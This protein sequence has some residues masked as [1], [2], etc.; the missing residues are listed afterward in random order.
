MV[1]IVSDSTC[2]LTPELAARYDLTIVPLHILLGDAEYRDGENITQADIFKWADT[3]KT[4][5]K[6]SAVSIE[7]TMAAFKPILDAGNEIIAFH[8]SE[9]MSTTGNMMRMAAQELDAEDRI[10]V[11]NSENLTTCVGHLAIEASIMA[12]AGMDR[13][14][15]LE[16]IHRLIP[17]LRASFVVDTLIYLYRGG[18]CNAVAALAGGML[19]LHPRIFVENGAMDAGKKY[20]GKIGAVVRNYA[21]DMEAD[22]LKAKKERVFITHSMQGA[23]MK[24]VEETEAYL[25][26]LGHFDEVLITRTGGVVSSHCGPGTLGILFI[27]GE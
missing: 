6:T 11:V 4:T 25:K 2:D 22:L 27:A 9:S 26:S 15:I 10:T 7:D 12:A 20:R 18:R 14:S 1:K 16:E 19:R 5:P 13:A 3:H 8:I 24:I 17:R 21:K 23:D